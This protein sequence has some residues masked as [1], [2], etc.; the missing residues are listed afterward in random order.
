MAYPTETYS[1]EERER[2]RKALADYADALRLKP[3]GVALKIMQETGYALDGDA[4]RKRVA[5]FLDGEHRQT[6]DFIGAVA[7]YLRKVPPPQIEESAATLAAFFSRPYL[8]KI[9]LEPLAGRYHAYV[10]Y[11]R[12]AKV[13]EGEAQ[14]TTLSAWEFKPQPVAELTDKI[15]YG[16]IELRPLDKYDALLVSEAIFNLS[17][18]PQVTA[19]PNRMPEAVDAGVFVPFG[20]TERAV[21]RFL[22]ATKSVLE[23]RLYRLYQVNDDPLTLRGELNFNGGIGRVYTRDSA[24]PLFPDY[25]IELV[26]VKTDNADQ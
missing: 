12:R 21:P 11:D 18:D 6:D 25:E 8:R 16:T 24:D 4:G 19:F 5:R 3:Q 22:M 1:D 15:A 2:L 23:S 9:D 13:D 26:R 7:R 20:H 10:S 17:I 14:V